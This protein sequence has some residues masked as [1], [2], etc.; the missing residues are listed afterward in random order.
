M[1]FF[2]LGFIAED[3]IRPTTSKNKAER[4]KK[5]WGL[6][7]GYKTLKDEFTIVVD[8]VEF[9]QILESIA[10]GDM[11]SFGFKQNKPVNIPSDSEE[12]NR[13]KKTLRRVRTRRLP[14]PLDDD[15]EDDSDGD[16]GRNPLED[17]NRGKLL[18]QQS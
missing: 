3:N 5:D 9:Q 7:I 4:I 14:S 18:G 6:P 2:K 17:R 11:R 16:Q 15:S 8:A 12:S 13:Q 1:Y 10:K